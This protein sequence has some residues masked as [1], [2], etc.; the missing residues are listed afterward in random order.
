MKFNEVF[1]SK[2]NELESEVKKIGYSVQDLKS[3]LQELVDKRPKGKSYPVENPIV[4]NLAL[5]DADEIKLIL[6]GD[7]PGKDEQKKKG[8]L[9]GKAGKNARSF[10]YSS[11]I[12]KEL[13]I[14]NFQKNVIVLNKTPIHTPQTKDLYQ[15]RNTSESIAKVLEESQKIMA[16]ILFKFHKAA[17]FGVPVWIIGYPE[18][19]DGDI[20]DPYIK[21]L[22]ELYSDKKMY[23]K[24]YFYYHFSYGWFT[25]NLEDQQKER[26]VDLKQLGKE[27][28]EDILGKIK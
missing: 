2:M 1:E 25:R 23:E 12:A 18:M 6:V 22:K 21:K 24:M 17:D 4:R 14:K 20:F 13:G 15:F 5:K 26:Q 10:F 28:M 19:R 27:Y 9:I 8:Y 11:P 3:I 7:N 16:E